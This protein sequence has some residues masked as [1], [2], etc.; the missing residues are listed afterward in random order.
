MTELQD[1]FKSTIGELINQI[2]GDSEILNLITNDTSANKKYELI[3]DF[4]LEDLISSDIEKK[5]YFNKC[6]EYFIEHL[7][8]FIFE[9]RMINHT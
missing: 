2:N 9:K 4:E 1:K 6:I 8:K 7:G 3:K 5:D